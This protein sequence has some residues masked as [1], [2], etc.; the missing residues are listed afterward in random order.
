MERSPCLRCYVYMQEQVRKDLTNRLLDELCA[1][2]DY[3]INHIESL[4]EYS[5]DPC[6][7]DDTDGNKLRTLYKNI[8]RKAL[9]V[10]YENGVTT[11]IDDIQDGLLEVINEFE[12]KKNVPR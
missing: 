1:N 11:V 5:H 8:I 9:E 12:E 7:V 6:I 4:N 10:G 3:F 2:I